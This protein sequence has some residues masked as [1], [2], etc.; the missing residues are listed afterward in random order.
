GKPVQLHL[1]RPT[2]LASAGVRPSAYA[3]V[4]IAA[5]KDGTITVWDAL[6]WASDGFK[7]A[8]IQANFLPYVLQ[9]EHRRVKQ[10]GISCNTGPSRAWRAPNHPQTC[11]LTCTAIDDLA[12]ALGMDPYDVFL[13]N[14]NL[15]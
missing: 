14:L 5:K 12:A 3:N 8:T 4:T 11:A 2:E 1:D 10:T 13:K 15:S 9:P 6:L 7:G